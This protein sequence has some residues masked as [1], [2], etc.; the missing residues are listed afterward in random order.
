MSAIKHILAGTSRPAPFLVFGPP[1][2]GKTVTI[3][4]AMKQVEC[5]L[6]HGVL[7]KPAICG[8]FSASMISSNYSRLAASSNRIGSVC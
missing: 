3:V 6:S 7:I 2:T 8:L 1:G 4:E 5:L